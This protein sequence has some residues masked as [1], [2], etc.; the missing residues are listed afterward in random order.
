MIKRPFPAEHPYA[1]H[2]E[3]KALFPKFDSA[4]DPKKGVEAR[5]QMPKNDEMP[6]NPYDVVVLSKTKGDALNKIPLWDP[7]EFLKMLKLSLA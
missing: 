4:D 7:D 5:S 6:S 2:M 3:R 1:S